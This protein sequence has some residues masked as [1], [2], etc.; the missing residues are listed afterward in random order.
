MSGVK[1]NTVTGPI[2]SGDLGKTLMHEH[3][4]ARLSGRETDESFADASPDEM[5]AICIDRIEEMKSAG[6]TSM[7]DPCPIDLGR[8]VRL[9]QQVASRTGFNI[10]AATGLFNAEFGAAH[11]RMKFQ[12]R[13]HDFIERTAEFF[14]KEIAAGIDGTDIK[15]GIIKVATGHPV[16]TDYERAVLNAAAIASL[17][18][19]VP[20]TTHTDGVLGDEQIAILKNAGVSPHRIIVGHSCCS[21]DHDYHMRIIDGGAYIGFD[22][23]GDEFMQSD[24]VRV[25]S[26]F[27]L[28]GKGALQRVIVSHDSLA[29]RRGLPPEVS[30]H[31]PLHF[32]RTIVP[33][34]QQ[35]GID[36]QQIDV[37]L[38]D[39]P[40]RYFSQGR[41]MG[42]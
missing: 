1:I 7:I 28:I 9:A 13:P 11:W 26:L 36:D 14:V 30:T 3:L 20:I 15:A 17:A 12:F 32:T 31:S 34:L 38:I 40:G 4:V 5:I 18:T 35:S 33:I 37:M 8:D 10:I 19:G 29:C 39:N 21:D 22:R 16:I 25:R 41:A 6:F 24:E 23:F 2:V 42:V 27:K